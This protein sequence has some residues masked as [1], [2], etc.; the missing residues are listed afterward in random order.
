MRRGRVL[1]LPPPPAQHTVDVKSTALPPAVRCSES[2]LS[3]DGIFLLANGLHLFL[4][5]GASSPPEL[6]QGIFNVPSLAH[7][8][9]HMVGVFLCVCGAQM[10][11][12]T[13]LFRVTVRS[14]GGREGT[15]LCTG[16]RAGG[17]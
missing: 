15:P 1:T 2:R 14:R 6:V 11:S 13:A 7:I 3:E 9:T 4:W 10:G 17:E 12:S 5:L 8:S 16:A